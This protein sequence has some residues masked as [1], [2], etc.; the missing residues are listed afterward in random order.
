[1]SSFLLKHDEV[2][3]LRPSRKIVVCSGCS[4]SGSSFVCSVLAS[5]LTRMGSVSVTEMGKS[6]FFDALGLEKHFLSRGFIDYFGKIRAN[7]RIASE[8]SNMF[9]GI[10][11][12]VR[13]SCDDEPL[14]AAE[15]FRCFYIPKE[16]YCI[17]DCSGLDQD[18]SMALLAEADFP[19]VV[20]DP[21]PSMLARSRS[22]L[23]KIRITMPDAVLIANKM[24]PGVHSNELSRFLG[25][26]EYFSIS[27]VPSE[28]I[29]K[30]EYNSKP[31]S[32][33]AE[34]ASMLGK[35]QDMLCR[36]FN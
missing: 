15:L 23:E 28:Y 5:G 8:P 33:L 27:S 30:A 34:T 2:K 20:I 6:H 9:E 21:L 24:N 36:L 22:F 19:V 31:V 26:K 18:S 25:T 35:T 29:Y 10:N 32:S 7:E 1:M 11:W 4:G 3:E 13:N 12:L 17:F 16:E 14:T